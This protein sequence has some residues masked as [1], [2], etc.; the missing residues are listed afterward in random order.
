MAR[1]LAAGERPLDWI[2]RFGMENRSAAA[3]NDVE[4]TMTRGAGNVYAYIPNYVALV[5]SEQYGANAVGF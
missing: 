5:G 4:D 3:A 1:V 2:M